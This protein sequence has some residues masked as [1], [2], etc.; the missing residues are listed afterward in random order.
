MS[1]PEA[2]VGDSLVMAVAVEEMGP[3]LPTPAAAPAGMQVTVVMVASAA[4]APP[5]VPAV[6]DLGVGITATVPVSVAAV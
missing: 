5:T 6:P 1:V 2:P 3:L 4:V